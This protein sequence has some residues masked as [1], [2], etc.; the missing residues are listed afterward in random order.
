MKQLEKAIKIQ[1]EVLGDEHET[2]KETLTQS[3]KIQSMVE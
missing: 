2:T 1:K 3:R